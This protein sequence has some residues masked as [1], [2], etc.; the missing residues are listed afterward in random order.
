MLQTAKGSNDNGFAV[1]LTPCI[2]IVHLGHISSIA[3][4]PAFRYTC[5]TLSA[6]L[7]TSSHGFLNVYTRATTEDEGEVFL[8][9][10]LSN[11]TI[12]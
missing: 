2:L 5:Y 12:L 1:H 7:N 9:N 6:M 10:A 8:S 11:L 3:A 4:H